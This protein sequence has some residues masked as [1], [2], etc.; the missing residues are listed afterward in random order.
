M[1]F[2]VHLN[3]KYGE[4]LSDYQESFENKIDSGS[5]ALIYTP[6]PGKFLN[7]KRV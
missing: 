6:R 2:P 4:I 1:F 3:H 7:S 5:I